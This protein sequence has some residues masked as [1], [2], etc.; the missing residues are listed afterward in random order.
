MKISI[1][2]LFPSEL[3]ITQTGIEHC[4]K[5]FESKKKFSPIKI[6]NINGEW[7]VRNGSHRVYVAKTLGL[8][9]IEAVTERELDASTQQH[10]QEAL[11]D[12]KEAGMKGFQSIPID[13]DDSA[14]ARRTRLKDKEKKE[15]SFFKNLADQLSEI[16][17]KK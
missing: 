6:V 16:P 8:S 3:S 17:D 5:D 2:E 9:E 4:T 7:I 10:L 13:P 1:S 12:S 14:R 15:N 11:K